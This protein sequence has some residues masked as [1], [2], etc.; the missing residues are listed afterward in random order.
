MAGLL[1]GFAPMAGLALMPL[2]RE[3]ISQVRDL[4]LGTMGS[5]KPALS[6]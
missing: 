5:L 6:C 3:C 1:G 4:L 2:C